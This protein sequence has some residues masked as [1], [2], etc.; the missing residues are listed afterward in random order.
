[1]KILVVDDSLFDRMVLKDLL[2]KWGYEV[3]LAS[4]GQE[5]LEILKGEDPPRLLIVDWEMP[6]MSGVELCAALSERDEESDQPF[7]YRILLTAKD[8]D[9]DLARALSYGAH[10][11]QVKPVK[12][13]QMISRINVGIRFVEM[14]DKLRMLAM[15]DG[16]TGVLNRRA[17]YFNLSKEIA[18]CRRYGGIFC[19]L[20]LDID[21][22]KDINDTYG[23]DAGD[24]VLK[25]L[26]EEIIRIL[27]ASDYLGRFGGEEFTIVLSETNLEGALVVAE[28]IRKALA[29]LTVKINGSEIHF[30]VSIGVTE[31]WPEDN[32][33]SIVG[34]ADKALYAAK[35]GGRNKVLPG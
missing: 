15:T 5:A 23:H 31:F 14:H 13:A 33:D 2:E 12:E 11:Y 8:D 17:F 34:R 35:N 28:R 27:R 22:F 3:V 16:L 1:M 20:M 32:E 10:D 9:E 24:A 26:T 7:I 6:G 25:A 18:R 21:H 19:L 29:A 4:S 30:T